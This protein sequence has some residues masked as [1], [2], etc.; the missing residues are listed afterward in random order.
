MMMYGRQIS[1][2]D[3]VADLVAPGSPVVALRPAFVVVVVMSCESRSAG[4]I[5][6][7]E[8]QKDLFSA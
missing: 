7:C 2:I 1:L 6:D 4:R 8:E 3:L 5:R